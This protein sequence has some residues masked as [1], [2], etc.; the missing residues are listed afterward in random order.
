M[1]IDETIHA[2]CYF[3]MFPAYFYFGLIAYNRRERIIALFYF[4]LSVF[5]AFM[6]FNLSLG[7]YFRQL[8]PF[9]YINT[10]VIVI[11]TIAVLS[12]AATIL[13]HYIAADINIFTILECD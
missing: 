12:R 1:S 10:G 7:V 13:Y 6:L 8:L 9:F 2:I 3:L 5:F 11:M 4:S